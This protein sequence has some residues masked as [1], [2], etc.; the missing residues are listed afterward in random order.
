MWQVIDVSEDSSDGEVGAFFVT[1][2]QG[3]ENRTV[4]VWYTLATDSCKIAC[5]VPV[6]LFRALMSD[7]DMKGEMAEAVKATRDMIRDAQEEAERESARAKKALD[8]QTRRK[9]LSIN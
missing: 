9:L 8:E 5:D 7:P 1:L 6:E 3:M 2:Q 4:L